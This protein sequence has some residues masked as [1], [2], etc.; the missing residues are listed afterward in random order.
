MLPLMLTFIIFLPYTVLTDAVAEAPSAEAALLGGTIVS[1]DQEALTL[2]ILFPTGESRALPVRDSRL[3]HGLNV[4]DHVTFELN[5]E[6]TLIK[7][8]KLPTDP[9]N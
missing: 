6:Q 3:L 7:I 1:I 2:T 9:A 4:G 8:A 5:Q